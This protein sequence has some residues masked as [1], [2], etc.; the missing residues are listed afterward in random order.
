MYVFLDI[1]CSFVCVF[2]FHV[3]SFR[4]LW[5]CSVVFR[6]CLFCGYVGSIVGCGCCYFVV[7]I[8]S[9]QKVLSCYVV[10]GLFSVVVSV[11][12]YAFC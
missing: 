4:V 9:R 3:S 7:C 11:C 8:F 1:V 10:C 6:F 2:F 5:C 12:D